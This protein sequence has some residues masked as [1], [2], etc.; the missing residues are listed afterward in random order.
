MPARAACRSPVL[1]LRKR[2]TTSIFRIPTP[3][4]GSGLIE[5]LAD[6]TLLNNQLTNNNKP[7]LAFLALFNAM[8]MT[9]PSPASAGSTE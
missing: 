8:A 6:S 5:N 9:A 7:T 2:P 4:F 1:I 3:V